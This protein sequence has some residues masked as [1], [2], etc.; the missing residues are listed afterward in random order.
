MTVPTD[1]GSLR[2]IVDTGAEELLLTRQAQET[3]HLPVQRVGQ[4]AQISI[5]QGKI[6]DLHLGSVT[7]HEVPFYTYDNQD[8]GNIANWNKAHPEARVDGLMGM[9]VLR[10]LAIGINPRSRRIQ[11]WNPGKLSPQV[12]EPFLTSGLENGK[13]VAVRQ[14]PIV[15]SSVGVEV[16][17]Q[18]G[19]VKTR[20]LLDTGAA[21]NMVGSRL[22]PYLQPLTASHAGT[23]SGV[24]GS[25]PTAFYAIPSLTLDREVFV[26]P[27]FLVA[28]VVDQKQICGILGMS[29]FAEN[30]CILDI[31]ARKLSFVR[32]ATAASAAQEK[33]HRL[34]I[35]PMVTQ[36]GMIGFLFAGAAKSAGLQ[37]EDIVVQIDHR[38][39]DQ[40]QDLNLSNSPSGS[41]TFTL[42]SRENGAVVKKE[43]DFSLEALQK[44]ASAP[45][46]LGEETSLLPKDPVIYHFPYGALYVPANFKD[47]VDRTGKD[48]AL[49]TPTGGYIL[50]KQGPDGTASHI[51]LKA[52]TVLGNGG[53][54]YPAEPSQPVEI[55]SDGYWQERLNGPAKSTFFIANPVKQK[56]L[57]SD[58]KTMSLRIASKHFNTA[59]GGRRLRDE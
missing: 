37:P 24:L 42:M 3:L 38:P 46:P 18:I 21:I 35:V 55:P 36:E 39:L 7:L 44:A 13:P 29:L 2:L 48:A 19:N 57:P 14:I 59:S 5:S 43:R 56:K 45:S 58:A 8:T 20:L 53:T 28:G 31:P 47:P 16:P 50:P 54:L 23:F 51:R 6:P 22:A 26:G 30:G 15:L 10:N 34:G 9:S 25:V 17:V 27:W 40:I 41:I 32:T 49:P 1:K 33:L 11:F 4:N 12:A 52:S